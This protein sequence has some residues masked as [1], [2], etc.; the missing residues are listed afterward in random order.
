[1]RDKKIWVFNAGNAFSGNPKWLFLYVINYRKDITPYWL[2]YK[3]ELVDQMRSMGYQAFLFGSK[4]A[5]QVGAQA[6]VYVVDQ[7]KE[8]YQDYLEGVTVLNLWHG[9]GCKNIENA[10]TSGYM[11]EGIAKKHI[12]N[13]S[14]YRRQL[15]LVTSPLME[16]H[17]KEQCSID[18]ERVIRS[19]YPSC[20]YP[21]KVSTYDHDVLTMKGLTPDTKLAVYA[22]TFRDFDR[23]GFFSK[24]LPDVDALVKALEA[25]G[26]LLI[27]KAHP[28]MEKDFQFQN[29]KKQYGSNPRLLFW[30]NTYD[31]YEIMDKINLAII[32]Y[33][34]IFYD[35]LAH[36][37]KRFVRY[38]FDYGDGSKLRDFAY[39]YMEMTC[40]CVCNTFNELLESVKSPTDTS[41]AELDRINTLFWKYAEGASISD[42]VDH[43]LNYE[44]TDIELP[45]LYSFDIFDTLIGRTCGNPL[46]VFMYVQGKMIESTV[47][48]PEYFVRSYVKIRRWA[49]RNCR[50]LM[51]KTAGLRESDR[52]EIVFDDIFNRMATLYGLNNTQTD[53]LKRWELECEYAASIPIEENISKVKNLVAAGETVLL[54][55]DMYLPEPFVRKLLAKADPELTQLPLFLSSSCGTQKMKKTLFLTAYHSLDYRFGAWIHSGDSKQSDVKMPKALGIIPD[56]YAANSKRGKHA[57]ELESFSKTYDTL[58]VSSIMSRFEKGKHSVEDTFAYCYASLYFVPYVYWVINHALNRGIQSLYFISRDGHHLKKIADEIIETRKLPLKAHYIYGSRKAWRIPSQIDEIDSDFFSSHGNFTGVCDYDSLL[59]AADISDYEFTNMFPELASLKQETYFEKETCERV[60]EILANSDLYRS[61]LLEKAAQEREIVVKYIQ[62]EIDSTENFAFVEFW[63]RGYTQSCFTR[64]LHAAF[65]QIERTEYYYAR[66][67]YPSTESD[68]RYNFVSNSYSMVFIEALFANV[69]YKSIASYEITGTGHVEPVIVNTEY[70]ARVFNALERELPEFSRQF[71][72]L[73]FADFEGT[74]RTLFDFS[75]SNFHNHVTKDVYLEC[76]AP[77]LYSQTI[78]GDL[79]EYAPEWTV[80]DTVKKARG[81][82]LPTANKKMSMA[83][84]RPI[85]KFAYKIYRKIRRK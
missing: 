1:M 5:E 84:S 49:E 47:S 72:G 64:L 43:V 46:G 33:S 28:Q 51:T 79:T 55:S 27:V 2:C 4:R 23:H 37:V 66:S 77:L 74:M 57:K 81:I 69:P 65:P 20:I 56:W 52:T 62:Q 70:V 41:P 8:V 60:V 44:P 38:V 31:F 13:E 32:D 59:E 3:K 63:A 19:G 16:E 9:V 30:D 58:Q 29:L 15:F 6:G 50:Q 80:K 42:I 71:A 10:V 26:Y 53:L 73:E 76:I 39:N 22:P 40:G 17:F 34:S 14:V 67:I 78:Y 35:L 54:I 24:A 45:T 83:R 21:D 12:R 85:F 11:D 48:F 82:D 25:G 18:E 68:V 7:N 36:G 75:L 61:Y